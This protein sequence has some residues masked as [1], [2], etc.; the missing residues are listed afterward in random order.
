MSGILSALNQRQLLAATAVDGPI[1]VIAGPGTGKT[2]TLIH[3]LVYLV[4]EARVPG[5]NLLAITFT[6]K[7]ADEMRERVKVLCHMGFDLS[8]IWIG[9]IHS[10]CYEI[11]KHEGGILK[12][13]ENFEIISPSDRACIIL[14]LAKEFFGKSGKHSIKK[15]DLKISTEKNSL[16]QPDEMSPFCL[17]YQD[18]MRRMALLDFDDLIIKTLELL[19]NSPQTAAKLRSRFT[20]ISVDEYQDINF[21]QYSLIKSL[22]SPTGNICA[23]GDADQAIYSFRGAQVEIFLNFQK[24]FPEAKV[25]HL[26]ENYRSSENILQAAQQ[27]I[28]KNSQRIEKRLMATKPSGAQIEIIEVE[29]EQEEADFVAREIERLVGGTSFE[30]LSVDSGENS[31]GFGDIAV[32]YRMNQQSSQLKKGIQKKGI[33]VSVATTRSLYEEPDIKPIINFLE[34]T[35]N[36]HNDFAL[37]EILSVSNARAGL[38]TIEKLKKEAESHELS[39]FSLL[40]KR[41]L[42]ESPPMNRMES[43]SKIIAFISSII[44]KSRS[45]SIERIIEKLWEYLFP[46]ASIKSDNFFE[47]ITSSMP[48]SNIPASEGA[49]LFLKKI[50]LLKDGEIFIQKEREA[51][52]LMTV[53]GAKGLE[54]PV[55]FITGLEQGVFPFH[56]GDDGIEK[57]DEEE[58]R[59]LF[60][61]AMTRA[62]KKLY[63]TWSQ[64]RFLFGERKKM[65]SS[66][67]L[68]DIPDNLI[69]KKIQKPPQKN[70]VKEPK[71]L[72]LFA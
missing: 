23:V 30:T 39:L 26:E 37:T 45:V 55:V 35:A 19:K 47:L 54:F 6:T 67:F 56:P 58:E 43:L 5:E 29:G 42:L 3:R 8:S 33:P 21:L 4:S 59:R 24:D 22:C 9:T 10:L 38:K 16:I 49:P 63:I 62:K 2:R 61:V 27:V 51:V 36:P 68:K 25:V 71:Q 40:K 52:R 41:Y 20:H 48:F 44:D 64:S 28:I 31:N 72:K 53:H 46:D 1:L 14:S 17:A 70:R 69:I 15:Y 7:A 32:L 11:L 60:Y 12:L 65:S 57:I 13:P 34:L 66:I 50:S 18:V